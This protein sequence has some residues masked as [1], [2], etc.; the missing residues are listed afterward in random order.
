MAKGKNIK[1][2]ETVLRDGQ[3]SLIATRMKTEQMIPILNKMDQAGFHALEVWGGATF[4]SCIRYLNEDPWERLRIIRRHVKNTKLQMLLRGQ[5]ILGYKNYADDVVD[6]F[7]KR[8]VENGIDIIR[9]FDALND[10]RNLEVAAKATKKYGAECQLTMSYTTS[11]IHTLD[12]FVDLGKK[13]VD[14]GADSICIKDMAGILLPQDAYDLITALKAEVDVPIDLHTHSTTGVAQMTYQ[15]A[16]EAGVDIVDTAISPF[17]GGTS[18]PPTEATI[19]ALENL[20]YETG[21]DSEKIFEIADYFKSVRDTFRQNGILDPK[22]QDIEPKTLM[23][24]VPGGMLS[25]LL[26]Q[27]KA[28]HLEEKFEATLEEVPRVREDLGYPPLVT[29]LSQMV[30]IQ[31]VMNVITGEPYKVVPTEIKEYVEGYYGKPPAPIKE[32]IVKKILPNA[33]PI[34]VRPADLLEP[35][36]PQFRKEIG[37]LA[38]NEDDLLIYALFPQVGREFLERQSLDFFE[39]PFDPVEM[40]IT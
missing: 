20:G 21:V 19:L 6:L 2:V 24:K 23:Y 40:S 26:S 32:E 7:V 1:I 11:P 15:K 10:L 27:L 29:P 34:T 22:V 9:T 5:N 30:G 25:N 28:Q 38:K 3:Q 13:L 33:T 31:A 35:Q 16:A 17:G 37:D 14:L 36:L 12:Y 8:A 4:D 18:Q 39:I